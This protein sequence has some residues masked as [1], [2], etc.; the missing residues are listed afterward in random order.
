MQLNSNSDS[1]DLKS[2]TSFLLGGVTISSTGQYPLV[3]FVRNINERYRAVWGWIF[4]AYGGWQWDDSNQ[5]DLPQA[6]ATLTSGTAT[7]ALPS[8]ALTVRGIDILA[9][10]STTLWYTLTPL[11]AELIQQREGIDNFLSTNGNPKYYR[12]IGDTVELFPAP[13][14]TQASSLKVYFDRDISSFASTDT[15]K[16][17]GFASPYHRALSIGA[18][19][20]FAQ[21]H[22]KDRVPQLERDWIRYEFLIKKFYQQ[23][24]KQL[25]PPKMRTIDYKRDFK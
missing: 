19:L 24:F 23:R 16:T 22:L 12:L 13:N 1:Q 6:T 20:D 5:T 14:Y 3:D 21:I 15:T 4:E 7:Y 25:F 17:P 10:G 2:D 11:T 8:G 9:S 18:A